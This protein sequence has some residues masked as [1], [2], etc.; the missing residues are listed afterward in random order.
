LNDG[1]FQFT[2]KNKYGGIQK[3]ENNVINRELI[4]LSGTW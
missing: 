4:K 1:T 2:L 3:I